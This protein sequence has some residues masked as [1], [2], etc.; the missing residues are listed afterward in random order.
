MSVLN[1]SN[2][3]SGA[4]FSLSLPMASLIDDLIR[5]RET[6]EPP[7]LHKALAVVEL[8]RAKREARNEG[9]EDCFKAVSEELD[10]QQENYND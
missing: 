8:V 2:H 6:K 9:W 1:Q 7:T 10:N 4:E 3:K 5:Y